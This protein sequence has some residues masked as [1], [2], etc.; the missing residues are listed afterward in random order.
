MKGKLKKKTGR[1]LALNASLGI[2]FGFGLRLGGFVDFSVRIRTTH[3]STL[4]HY[5]NSPFI[6]P[7]PPSLLLKTPLSLELKKK[8][9]SLSSF[10][11]S[12]DLRKTESSDFWLFKLAIE[13]Q[14]T[15]IKPKNRRIMVSNAFA[16]LFSSF[17]GSLFDF[18]C[19][20]CFKFSVFSRLKPMAFLVWLK[21]TIFLFC[22][23]WNNSH[24]SEVGFVSGQIRYLPFSFSILGFI[25]IHA[26]D[27]DWNTGEK[28]FF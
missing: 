15:A 24:Q 14:E 28:C 1:F 23:K 20:F 8:K 4:S 6:I 27:L 13:N 18:C 2:R 21:T 19:G 5:K 3:L 22:L 17:F 16:C 12:A 11:L 25:Q 10:Y 9:K 26:F 7:Q